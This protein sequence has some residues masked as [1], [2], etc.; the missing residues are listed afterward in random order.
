VK[1]A[2]GILTVAVVL[3]AA[4]WGQDGPGA[5]VLG[6]RGYAERALL[7]RVRRLS[8]VAV[9]RL[10]RVG[11]ISAARLRAELPGI[12]ARG[13]HFYTLRYAVGNTAM[14]GG[15]RKLTVTV[16]RAG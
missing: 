9:E 7:V 13:S 14:D 3:T 5:P 6:R 1:R 12:V 2:G 15:L 10:E 16:D 11:P 8:E 4:L